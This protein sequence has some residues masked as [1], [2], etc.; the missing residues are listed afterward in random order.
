MQG[1]FSINIDKF[2]EIYQYLSKTDP[3]FDIKRLFIDI[4]RLYLL[5]RPSFVYRF[6]LDKG[7]TPLLMNRYDKFINFRSII[8]R[9]QFETIYPQDLGRG[10]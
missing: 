10:T 5:Y 9:F 1:P 4:Y 7:E 6:Q 8:H 2:I 3:K